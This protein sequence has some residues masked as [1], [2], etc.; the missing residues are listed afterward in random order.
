MAKSL[1]ALALASGVACTAAWS[2]EIDFTAAKLGAPGSAPKT[3]VPVTN[4]AVC[5]DG[6][7]GAYYHSPGTGSGANKWYVHHQG[8]GWCESLDDCLSR[9]KGGLGSSKSYAPTMQLGGGYF[10]SD[11]TENP[12][13]YNWNK[14]H[15]NYCDGA[16]FSGNND[17]VQVY[18][19]TSLHWRGSRIRENIVTDLMGKGLSDATD[20]MV[21]GCSAGGLA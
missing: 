13:M 7:P 11:Q 18:K 8:G 12:L 14:V 17:T 21:S 9:S 5:L 4:G 15:M 1:V 19:N 2:E 20:L 16:S 6:S 10:S 3:S